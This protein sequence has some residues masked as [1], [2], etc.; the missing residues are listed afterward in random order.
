MKI[1]YFLKHLEISVRHPTIF[2]HLRLHSRSIFTHEHQQCYSIAWH[3]PINIS[4]DMNHLC[5]RKMYFSSK[6]YKCSLSQFSEKWYWKNVLHKK[7]SS[8]EQVIKILNEIN[9]M[10]FIRCAMLYNFLRLYS[11]GWNKSATKF[12]F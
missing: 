2:T 12:R 7:I 5:N 8:H 1:V 4:L 11:F 10:E 6:F 3:K 9:G